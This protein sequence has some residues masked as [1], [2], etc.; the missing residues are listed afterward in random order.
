MCTLSGGGPGVSCIVKEEQRE[1]VS[2][3]NIQVNRKE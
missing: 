1:K 3:I 2:K